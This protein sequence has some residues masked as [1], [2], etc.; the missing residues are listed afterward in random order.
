MPYSVVIFVTKL[1][2]HL[3]NLHILYHISR[4]LRGP[5]METEETF[6]HPFLER[7]V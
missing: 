1:T 5:E 4:L 2:G 3:G 7:L 6:V